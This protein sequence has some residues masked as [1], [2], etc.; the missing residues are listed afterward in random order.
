MYCHTLAF[1]L[2]RNRGRVRWNED[3]LGE[4]EKNKPVRQKITEPKTPYHPMIEDDGSLS[5][6]RGGTFD[7]CIDAAEHAEAVRHALDDVASSTTMSAKQSGGWTSSDDEGQE[8][9][10]GSNRSASFKAHRTAHYDEFLKV[11]ELRRKGSF[12]EEEESDEDENSVMRKGKAPAS[13][14]STP[15]VNGATIDNGKSVAID[16]P[17]ANGS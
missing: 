16:P 15:A 9:D 1:A 11:K 13:S 6:I 10:E 7:E 3:N 5:P 8:D 14:S 2:I 17:S 12:M 4:I